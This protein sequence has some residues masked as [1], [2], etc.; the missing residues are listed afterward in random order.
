MFALVVIS[1][2]QI[3]WRW[4]RVRRP[5]GP[6]EAAKMKLNRPPVC[7]QKSGATLAEKISCRSGMRKK[8][9]ANM[10]PRRVRA[11]TDWPTTDET[12]KDTDSL[13]AKESNGLRACLKI[14]S[15]LGEG[16]GGVRLAMRRFM[17][18]AMIPTA[19][20]IRRRLPP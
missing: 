13:A 10:Q 12:R 20:D 9:R 3:S 14:R 1:I 8:M 4:A 17:R 11:R 16:G 2:V 18:F 7:E 15:G 19:S 5:M 6:A